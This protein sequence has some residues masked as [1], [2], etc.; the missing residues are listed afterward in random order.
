MILTVGG[1]HSIS[2]ATISG[3]LKKYH[4]LRVVYIGAH[5]DIS[6]PQYK[7]IYHQNYHGMVVSHLIGDV[8]LPGFN[9]LDDVFLHPRNL[10]Y[11]AIR[12]IDPD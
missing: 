9:W 2:S 11:I 3:M 4:D 7:N 5:P 1:D 10:V 12:D 6:N 8:K